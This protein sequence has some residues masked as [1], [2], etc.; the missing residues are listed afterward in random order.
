MQPIIASVAISSTSLSEFAV[1]ADLY[2]ASPSSV[3]QSDCIVSINL[4][5][6]PSDFLFLKDRVNTQDN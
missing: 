1:L 3:Y 6:Q 5:A 2:L 4:R